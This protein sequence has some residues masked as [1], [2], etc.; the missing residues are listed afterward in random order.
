M[1][2]ILK[3][4]LKC[5]YQGLRKIH[6]NIAFPDVLILGDSHAKV[7]Q[8]WWFLL[9]FPFKRFEVCSVKGAT[10][11]GLENPNSKTEAFT[12]FKQAIKQ[13]KYD[14][15]I[16][17]LGEVDIGF[18]IWYRADK[19]NIS[20]LETFDLAVTRYSNFLSML[21]K[22]DKKLIVI[23]APLPT[24]QEGVVK[25]KVAELRKSINAT[26]QERT[27]L[28]IR[29]NKE[30]SKFCRNRDIKYIDLDN[31]CLGENGIV[32]K[33]MINKNSNDH[34]YNKYEYAR[35]LSQRLKTII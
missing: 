9:K 31:I 7:F 12:T 5:I 10:V 19:Y 21:R 23:S 15:L 18:L 2:S 14:K 30:I 26:L 13:H 4:F 28:T 6:Y 29:F 25:G 34:H 20:I 11:T 32:K 24:I 17:L 8:H 27:E 22:I 1:P 3:P 16:V 33:Q 35:L